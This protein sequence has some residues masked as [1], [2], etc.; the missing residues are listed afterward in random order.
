MKTVKLSLRAYKRA[1]LNSAPVPWWLTYPLKAQ[2][3]P[4]TGSS[5]DI[6]N[7][8]FPYSASINIATGIAGRRD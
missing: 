4:L 5:Q 2:P 6:Y 7:E 8:P 3:T 1:L